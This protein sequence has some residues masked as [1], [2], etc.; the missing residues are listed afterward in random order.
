M[1]ESESYQLLARLYIPSEVEPMSIQRAVDSLG[2]EI[3]LVKER[4]IV[5]SA[6]QQLIASG[7]IT[8]AFART[9]L[10][11]EILPKTSRP[12]P[13]IQAI[14]ARLRNLAAA[15]SLTVIDRFLLPAK[16]SP[17]YPSTLQ[18]LLSV[19]TTGARRLVLITESSYDAGLLNSVSLALHASNPGLVVNHY[20]DSDFHD[21]FWIADETRGMVVGT[22]LNGVGKRFALLD[23]LSQDD[24]ADIVRALRGK[25][26][27]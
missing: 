12:A 14:E 2:V 11:E 26:I 1:S 21:R 17:D 27:L 10:D 15:D 23:G 7:S 24:T 16:F 5:D 6:V 22:S 9:R 8:Q 18:S 19:A 3:S 4:D 13:L 20:S 25:G